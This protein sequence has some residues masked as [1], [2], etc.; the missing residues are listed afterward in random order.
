MYVILKEGLSEIMGLSGSEVTGGVWSR[1]Y[2]LSTFV[3]FVSS[4][5][6]LHIPKMYETLS[7]AHPSPS[8]LSPIGYPAQCPLFRR[9]TASI[10]MALYHL[11]MLSAEALLQHYPAY[12]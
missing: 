7:K 12:Y 5:P 8:D 10:Q 1:S 6:L 11:V 9:H 2:A 3:I 4:L